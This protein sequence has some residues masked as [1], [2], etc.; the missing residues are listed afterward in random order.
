MRGQE[1]SQTRIPVCGD[2]SLEREKETGALIHLSFRPD[3]TAVPTNESGYHRQPDTVPLEVGRSVQA[4]E[5]AKS[6]ST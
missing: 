2:L 3:P 1:G 4:L 5:D 6:L